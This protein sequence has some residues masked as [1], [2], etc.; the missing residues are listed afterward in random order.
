MGSSKYYIA[1]TAITA[2]STLFTGCSDAKEAQSSQKAP[3]KTAIITQ[4][5]E[6]IRENSIAS[7]LSFQRAVLDTTADRS[8]TPRNSDR[9]PTATDV[10]AQPTGAVAGTLLTEIH[11]G[12]QKSPDEFKSIEESA[13]NDRSLEQVQKSGDGANVQPPPARVE[14]PIEPRADASG[15]GFSSISFRRKCSG[16]YSQ[17][18][19]WIGSLQYGYVNAVISVLDLKQSMNRELDVGGGK[20]KVRIPISEKLIR[21]MASRTTLPADIV[22][23]IL[24]GTKTLPSGDYGLWFEIPNE[25]VEFKEGLL[26]IV[27][28]NIEESFQGSSDPRL[29]PGLLD[30]QLMNQFHMKKGHV[31]NVISN[32]VQ[33]RTDGRGGMTFIGSLPTII[34]MQTGDI[35]QYS[36]RDAKIAVEQMSLT[37]QSNHRLNLYFYGIGGSSQAGQWV[38]QPIGVTFGNISACDGPPITPLMIDLSGQGLLLSDADRGANFDLKGNGE[39]VR[40]AWPMRS[41]NVF[42]GLPNAQGRIESIHDL[43]GANTIGPDGKT[44]QNGFVALAKYD[45][46]HDGVIDSKDEVFSKLVVW[47]NTTRDGISRAEQ[48]KTLDEI[49]IA[50]IHLSYRV[51]PA[52]D[53]HGNEFRQQSFVTMK[54]GSKRFIVD[55]WLVNH[56]IAAK[57]GSRE[58]QAVTML[59]IIA[60]LMVI[61]LATSRKAVYLKT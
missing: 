25:D 43:F 17:L 32:L 31:M 41:D 51:S 14:R 7:D 27:N 39:V 16:D 21:S 24:D 38:Y 50:S 6:L 46:N 4:Q 53:M 22:Q 26:K 1:I 9:A 42:L 19:S 33:I 13:L 60:A 45:L 49:G 15:I 36:I 37:E 48:M 3:T 57:T 10:G 54:D 8:G 40:T 47:S 18:N 34:R 52:N 59:S 20:I 2:A 28:G 56:S 35:A 12:N 44:S 58:Q 55:A 11:S 30:H 29:D 23:G 5:S 61:A